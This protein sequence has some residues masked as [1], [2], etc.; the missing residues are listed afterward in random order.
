MGEK[1]T[2]QG[3]APR[4]CSAAESTL[5]SVTGRTAGWVGTKSVDAAVRRPHATPGSRLRGCVILGE[6]LAPASVSKLRIIVTL[7]S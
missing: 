5:P 3:L 7:R 4:R 2:T 6:L 1:P